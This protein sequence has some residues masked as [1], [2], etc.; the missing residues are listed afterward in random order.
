MPA[1]EEFTGWPEPVEMLDEPGLQHAFFGNGVSMITY[2]F[3]LWFAEKK[4]PRMGPLCIFHN[5]ERD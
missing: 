3:V 5:F 2:R 1:G 4:R